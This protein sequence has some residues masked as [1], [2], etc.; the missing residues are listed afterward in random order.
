VSVD[1]NSVLGKFR[2]SCKDKTPEERASILE[3]DEGFQSKHKNYA[4]QVR[5]ICLNDQG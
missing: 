4:M 1:G 2:E 3:S 5:N